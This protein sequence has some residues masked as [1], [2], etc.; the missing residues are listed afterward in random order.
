M[1]LSL[2]ELKLKKLTFIPPS[3]T[4]PSATSSNPPAPS[5]PTSHRESAPRFRFLFYID[6]NPVSYLPWKI[7]KFRFFSDWIQT[8]QTR[9]EAMRREIAFLAQPRFLL[10][11]LVL[12]VFLIFAFSASKWV[13]PLTLLYYILLSLWI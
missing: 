9:G 1:L 6:T 10:L 3:S 7:T 5:S 11:F 12:S 8:E 4:P 13:F 2:N